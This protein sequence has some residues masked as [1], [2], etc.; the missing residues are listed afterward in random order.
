M[1]TLHFP[2]Q[3]A[4]VSYLEQHPLTRD[5]YFKGRG[6]LTAVAKVFADQDRADMDVDRGVRLTM[7]DLE[8]KIGLPNFALMAVHSTFKQALKDCAN[9]VPIKI[10]KK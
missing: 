6:I 1:I 5:P 4:I 10:E 8:Q 7:G 9:G 3:E 2:S